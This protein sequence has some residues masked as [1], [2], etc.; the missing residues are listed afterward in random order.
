MSSAF[1]YCDFLK[2]GEP[3]LVSETT[4]L[5]NLFFCSGLLAHEVIRRKAEN[6]QAVVTIVLV[7]LLKAVVLWRIATLGRGIDDEQYFTAVFVAKVDGLIRGE[8]TKI[9]VKQGF[10]CEY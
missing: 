8:A 7:E 6:D 10:V 3:D 1:L 5:L 9:L 2:H 4:E